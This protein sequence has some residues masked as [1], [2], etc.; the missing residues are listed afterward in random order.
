MLLETRSLG[1]RRLALPGV[2]RFL[3]VEGCCH[4][5]EG[6]LSATPAPSL[7]I[8]KG[9]NRQQQMPVKDR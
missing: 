4:G 6:S 7:R 1:L 3:Q 5:A 8:G 2:K 9:V